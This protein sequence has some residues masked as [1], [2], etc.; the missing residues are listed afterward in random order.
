MLTDCVFSKQAHVRSLN[1]SL[2]PQ[3]FF[4]SHTVLVTW[5]Q[6]N[7]KSEWK[8]SKYPDRHILERGTLTKST[9]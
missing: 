5:K 3:A 7:Q 9:V 6:E 8:D 4:L 2:I 1:L